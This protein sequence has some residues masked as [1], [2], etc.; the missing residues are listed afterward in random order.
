MTLSLERIRSTF[1]VPAHRG[2]P[3][4]VAGHP[5]TILGAGTRPGADAC[6][7]VRLATGE[8]VKADPAR[9][10]TYP[11]THRHVAAA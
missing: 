5:G 3:V 6:L 2:T 11:P 9:Q 10:V 7:R 4:T 1:D 8:I